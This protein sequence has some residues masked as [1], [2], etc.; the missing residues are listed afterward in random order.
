MNANTLLTKAKS[1]LTNTH[2]YFGMLA[3]RLKHE[4]DENIN[5]YASN[6]IRFRYNPTFIESCSKDELMFILTNCVMHHILAHQQRKLARRGFLWQLATDFAINNMLKKS[7]FKI[8]KGANFNNEFKNMYSEE[9][10]TI[11]KEQI[12][13]QGTNAFDDADSNES[14]TSNTKESIFKN[15]NKI[16]HELDEKDEE[17]WDYAATL[18][19][20]VA[21][22]NL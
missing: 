1:Q 12:E 14:L 9:I 20:E 17:N 21:Q 2:P 6:G 13:L 5:Y 7:G 16:K 19:K 22:K 15:M 8:P 18:A 4:E 11:L 3:S 10:Y